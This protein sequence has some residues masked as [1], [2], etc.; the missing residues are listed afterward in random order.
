MVVIME[1]IMAVIMEGT[2]G[3]MMVEGTSGTTMMEGTLETMM[4]MMTM[5]LCNCRCPRTH[6]QRGDRQQGRT[7]INL[8]HGYHSR[9]GLRQRGHS[10]PGRSH[11]ELHHRYNCRNGL[12]QMGPSQKGYSP[13]R[14]CQ[15][16]HR[17]SSYRGALHIQK[18]LDHPR[19]RRHHHLPKRSVG[20]V[21]VKAR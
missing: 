12:R 11:M 13:K 4:M 5:I 9:N 19:S 6:P 20:W 3:T 16:S 21:S 2:L 10:Q 15:S 18:L 1:A 8:H 7:H 17:R 14:S